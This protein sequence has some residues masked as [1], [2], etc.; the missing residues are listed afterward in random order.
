MVHLIP[1]TVEMQAEVLA[2]ESACRDAT[3]LTAESA[4]LTDIRLKRE[5]E[6]AYNHHQLPGTGAAIVRIIWLVGLFMQLIASRSAWRQLIAP[7]R[8]WLK[9]LI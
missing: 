6:Q 3:K 9:V 1:A 4:L 2:A 5:V 8:I 7:V